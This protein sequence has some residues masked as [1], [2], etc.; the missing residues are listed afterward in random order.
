MTLPPRPE[1]TVGTVLALD[2][3][4]S[5]VR[6]FVTDPARG[7]AFV[8]RSTRPVS[9]RKQADEA[10]ELDA[11]AYL[12][13]VTEC[14]DELHAGGQLYD[15]RTVGVSCQW[16]SLLAVGADGS[17]STPLLT[18]ADSRAAAGH[19]GR[20]VDPA[21]FHQRTGSWH[22]PLYWSAKIPWLEKQLGTRAARFLGISEYVT[23]ALLGVDRASVSMA[24]GTGLL[25]IG[26]LRWDDEALSLAGV[27]TG[28]LPGVG[29][30]DAAVLLPSW[31]A[32][33][34]DL[35]AARW[36]P[37]VGDGAAANLGAGCDETSG[38]VSVSVGTSAS[39]RVVQDESALEGR[40]LP[41]SVWRYRVDEQ[42][43][44]T[45]QAFSGG[46]NLFGWAR[47]VLAEASVSGASLDGCV[48]GSHG[49]I[50]LPFH[51]GSRPPDDV[52]S[53]SGA[54]VGMGQHTTATDLLAATMEG[55][56]LQCLAGVESLEVMTGRQLAPVLNGGALLRSSWWRRAFAAAFDGEVSVC[57]VEEASA[58]GA[59][60]M[61]AGWTEDAPARLP[62]HASPAD[63]TSMRTAAQRYRKVVGALIDVAQDG[64]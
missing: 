15:V 64:G 7:F 29:W 54:W 55:V 41:M 11:S 14:I 27:S 24:S 19:C 57:P 5:S 35:A 43:V 63:R 3:G 16:H 37:P 10:A 61:A 12:R 34:P 22:S 6:A 20:A 58:R 33:W 30:P 32:R 52:P 45:G 38:D 28:V 1:S 39:V 36:M 23:Q 49:V 46:G 40:P 31:A 60:I 53:S 17:A 26:A 21:A 51:L 50:A 56:V 42:R 18:W 9:L 4:S 8:A 44:V 48:P 13:S 25:D 2:L 59:A 47:G 62:V